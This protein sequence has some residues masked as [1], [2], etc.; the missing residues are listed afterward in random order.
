VLLTSVFEATRRTGLV[1]LSSFKYGCKRTSSLAGL[2][3][4]LPCGFWSLVDLTFGLDYLGWLFPC[5]GVGY[6]NFLAL[7][8]LR[9]P[10]SDA[11]SCCSR[12]IELASL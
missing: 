2:T 1:V 3:T 12:G 8:L 5:Y 7:L 4:S 6:N 9:W 10:F 11:A